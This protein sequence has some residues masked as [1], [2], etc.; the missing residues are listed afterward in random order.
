MSM[1]TYTNVL[2]RLGAVDLR[3]NVE[4]NAPP[5]AVSAARSDT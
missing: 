3:F 1:T 2:L 5:I 4:R